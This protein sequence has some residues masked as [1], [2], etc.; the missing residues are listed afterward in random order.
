M[1]DDQTGGQEPFERSRQ[2]RRGV[3][4]ACLDLE[5]ALARPAGRDPGSWSAETV[6]RVQVLVEA[7]QHHVRQSEG[8]DGLLGQ[9]VQVARIHVGEKWNTLTIARG[10]SEQ[11]NKAHWGQTGKSHS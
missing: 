9:I 3:Q 7:F 5:D 4:Q 10:S 2:H 11:F 1:A 6:A 8:P